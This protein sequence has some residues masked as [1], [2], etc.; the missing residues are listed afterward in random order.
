MT[1]TE[2][3][4]GREAV[5]TGAGGR[6]EVRVGRFHLDGRAYRAA[7]DPKGDASTPYD[8]TQVDVRLRYQVAPV[9]AIEVGGGRRYVDPEFA[10]Q[11]VGLAR[12]GLFSE[13]QL[14]RIASIWVRGAYL[15]GARF[16]GGGNA[17]L[18]FEF[19]LGVGVGTANG[20]FR[21]QMD[22]EFQRLDRQVAGTD[23][24]IQASLVR[25][26]IALGF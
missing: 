25:T 5:G 14:A 17:D 2:A 21:F 24:P 23:V 15:G 13:T 12:V 19:G 3:S 10:A 9:V 8:L 11:A 18:A 16:V 6:L 20:R 22:Y 7:L 4:E 26:G 1:Y